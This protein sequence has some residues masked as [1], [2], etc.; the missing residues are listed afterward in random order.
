M[1]G[2]RTM[3][4]LRGSIAALA[5]VALL[6]LAPGVAAAQSTIALDGM[7]CSGITARGTGLDAGTA[8]K[9][10]LVDKDDGHVLARGSATTDAKGAF[11]VRIGTGLAE[12]LTVRL[13]VTTSDGTKVGFAEH[14]MAEDAPMCRLPY[15][16]PHDPVMVALGGVL[17]AGGAGLV[18][19]SRR[20]GGRHL[21]GRTA[22]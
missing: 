18:T 3:R 22:V 2:R 6:A 10:T 15:T 21:P 17:L 14:R 13:D 8:L 16:G 11:R 5:A 1:K 4:A 12:V 9:L 19:G 7:G 20:R